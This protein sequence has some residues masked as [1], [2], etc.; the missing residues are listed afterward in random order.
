LSATDH[1]PVAP[2]RLDYRGRKMPL[3]AGLR[4]YELDLTGC[5]LEALP[6]DLQVESRLILDDSVRLQR[7]PENLK[8]GSLSVRNCVSLEALPEGL[9]CWFLDMTGCE[10]FHQWPKH[11]QVRNGSVI[12]RDC[13]RL[14]TLPTWL[15]RLAN[16]NLAGCNLI[17]RVPEQLTLT[18]WLDLAGT[19]ISALPVNLADARLRW[20]GVRINQRLAFAAH[21]LSATE[22]LQ[23]RNAELRRVMIERMGPL[24]FAQQAKA[25]VLDRDRD[26]GGERRL[27][28]IPLQE[29]EPL[30]GLNCRCPSTGRE[31]LL[32]VPPKTKTCH[33]AAAWIA[34]FDDPRDYHPDQ[35]T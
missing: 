20:R 17:D 31:Y 34:G 26:P 28:M 7:L 23:E 32:R 16:L 3:P 1:A 19:G 15:H 11:A 4:C 29:D 10:N 9:D 2:V 5:A 24:E 6:D 8:V 13:R 35:E 30:V 22:I 33:Q 14:T 12:L 18:G 25:K 27:L 21:E